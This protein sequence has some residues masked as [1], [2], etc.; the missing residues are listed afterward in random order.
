MIRFTH[1]NEPLC[2]QINSL[3]HGRVVLRKTLDDKFWRTTCFK[4]SA[5]QK[6]TPLNTFQEAIYIARDH[7]HRIYFLTINIPF[8]LF[9]KDRGL[10]FKGV[11][12]GW[13][14][15]VISAGETLQTI[16]L[17]NSIVCFYII[18]LM[19]M[20]TQRNTLNNST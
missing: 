11:E 3:S 16:L 18:L 17:G 13:L 10:H 12:D 19:T 8:T 1:L 7:K 15:N 6:K 2:Q 14:H 20:H 4:I 9:I 5:R